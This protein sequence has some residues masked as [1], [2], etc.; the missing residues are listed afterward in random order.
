MFQSGSSEH[1]PEADL[2]LLV[3]PER[4]FVIQGW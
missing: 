1:L 4:V 3:E 2:L